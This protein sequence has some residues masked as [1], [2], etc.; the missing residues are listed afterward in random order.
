MMELSG[1]YFITDRGLST[2]PD[3]D[4]V[5]D[6]VEGG[7]KIVQYREKYLPRDEMLAKS[8]EMEAICRGRALFII[9]DFADIAAECDADGVHIGQD[10]LDYVM[11]RELLGPE[12]I[13]GVTVH[14]TVEVMAA[15]EAGA[16]YLGA[17]PIYA[18]KTK[19]DAG[20]PAGIKLIED[21][22]AFCDTPI[23]AIGGI[24]ES[25]VIPVIA[26]GA[27]MVCAISATVAKKN[28]RDAVEVFAKMME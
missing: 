18:T 26:A 28:I 6:A 9:N 1:F 27:D 24:D 14:D 15:V 10:D 12:K 19:K 17:S 20:K 16:D 3:V 2:K 21:I 22:K 7:A 23:A 11:A 8:K 13:I 5:R 25:N 4:A